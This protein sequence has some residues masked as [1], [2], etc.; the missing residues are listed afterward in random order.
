VALGS[1]PSSP[2]RVCRTSVAQTA[3]HA[4]ARGAAQALRG[5]LLSA[6]VDAAEIDYVNAHGTGTPQNDATET[7]ALRQ[8]LGDAADRIAVSSTKSLIGHLLGAAGAVEA[9]A[10]ILAI[11]EGWAPPTLNLREPDPAYDLGYV[12]LRG[13]PTTSRATPVRRGACS[14]SQGHRAPR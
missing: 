14:S 9:I 2:V 5:A 10:T 1:S 7:I 3:P 4:E 11:E 12:P 6:G 13:R 8:V